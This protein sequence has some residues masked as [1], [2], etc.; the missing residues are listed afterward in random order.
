MVITLLMWHGVWI[1]LIIICLSRQRSMQ[2]GIVILL[3]L[4]KNSSD[5]LNDI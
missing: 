2:G 4:V 1:E 3:G 5:N